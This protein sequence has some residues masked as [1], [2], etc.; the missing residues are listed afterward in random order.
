MQRKGEQTIKDPNPW[1]TNKR[2]SHTNKLG[3]ITFE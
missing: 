1:D 2:Q 3:L